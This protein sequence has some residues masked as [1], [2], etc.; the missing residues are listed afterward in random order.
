MSRNVCNVTPMIVI[1]STE[2][3]LLT[4]LIL[5]VDFIKGPLSSILQCTPQCYQFWD[6]NVGTG[7]THFWSFWVKLRILPC[8]VRYW[9]LIR[10]T[11]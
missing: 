10:L 11:C 7:Q 9:Y 8:M 1:T 5:G 3:M 4:E 2:L 6:I